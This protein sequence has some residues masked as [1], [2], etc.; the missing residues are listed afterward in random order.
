MHCVT[1]HS[2][3]VRIAHC[4]TAGS[5]ATYIQEGSLGKGSSNNCVWVK[6]R[7][8]EGERERLV[9]FFSIPSGYD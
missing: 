5:V 1:Y 7:E 2:S 6:E 4:S 8:R 3:N 9:D